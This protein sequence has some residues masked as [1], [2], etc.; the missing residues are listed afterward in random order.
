MKKIILTLALLSM[1]AITILANSTNIKQNIIPSTKL[2][3]YSQI[4]LFFKGNSFSK[5][6][7]V[8]NVK[9]KILI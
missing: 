9:K 5:I 8:F 1:P 2:T 6:S 3:S 4:E 7:N